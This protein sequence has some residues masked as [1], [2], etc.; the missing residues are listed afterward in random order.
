MNRFVSCSLSAFVFLAGCGA[1][2]TVEKKKEVVSTTPESTSQKAATPTK[3]PEKTV[4]STKEKKKKAAPKEDKKLTSREKQQYQKH[5]NEGRTQHRAK[6]FKATI[7]A[8]DKA[9]A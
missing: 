1:K 4:K 5:L 2:P 9:L 6:D 8:F 3:E 7:A